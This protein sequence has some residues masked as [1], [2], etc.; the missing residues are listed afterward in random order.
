MSG[1]LSEKRPLGLFF[2]ERVAVADVA[3]QQIGLREGVAVAH[4][5]PQRIDFVAGSSATN[6][7]LFNVST[8]EWAGKSSPGL[9]KVDNIVLHICWDVS[10]II[11]GDLGAI[12]V[13]MP[14][15]H[16]EQPADEKVWSKAD[17]SQPT[18]PHENVMASVQ[19]GGRRRLG[20]RGFNTVHQ[21]WH[22]LRR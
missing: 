6:S 9:R 21:V 15:A 11:T 4:A 1:A 18:C 13:E 22:A 17:E 10:T 19:W 8:V 16:C 20:E 14:E 7:Q 5:E 3:A 12:V 2:A